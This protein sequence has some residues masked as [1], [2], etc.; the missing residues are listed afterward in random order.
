MTDRRMKISAMF[1]GTYPA[2]GGSAGTSGSFFRYLGTGGQPHL[3]VGHN[4]FTRSDALLDDSESFMGDT[5]RYGADLHGGVGLYHK[6]IRAALSGLESLGRHHDGIGAGREGHDHVDELTGPEPPPLV[7]KDSLEFDGTGGSVDRIVEKA[8]GP[9]LRRSLIIG[10]DRRHREPSG[11]QT[12]LDLGKV[13]LGNGKGYVDRSYL[14]D[15]NQRRIL[16]CLDDVP[17]MHRQVAGSAR[18]GRAY[19]AVGEFDPGVLHGGPVGGNIRRECLRLGAVLLILLLGH[20]PFCQ[21]LGIAFRVLA[22]IA[23]LDQIS[24]KICFRFFQG[25]GIGTRIYG[26]QE[27]ALFHVLPFGKVNAHHLTAHLGLDRH[28]GIGLHIADGLDLNRNRLPL[29]L[30]EHDRHRRLYRWFLLLGGAGAQRESRHDRRRRNGMPSP[31][32]KRAKGCH[33]IHQGHSELHHQSGRV[34]LAHF[35]RKGSPLLFPLR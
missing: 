30:C 34:S 20:D 26:K 17:R 24:G 2:Q 5:R 23:R 16:V 27:I 33:H 29:H 19:G 12:V 6:E 28:R 22:G 15:R 11:R 10:N 8:D 7:L 13:F 25:G 32:A 31:T 3:A 1:M 18:K 14:V 21:Q 9:L 4:R 35:A